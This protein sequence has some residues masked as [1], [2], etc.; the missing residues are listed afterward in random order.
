MTGT[1]GELGGDLRDRLALL[2]QASSLGGHLLVDYRAC[3]QSSLQ[4]L[5]EKAMDAALGSASSSSDGCHGRPVR[6]GVCGS[7]LVADDDALI[8]GQPL[9]PG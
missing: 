9:S 5:M 3:R 1:D 4:R 7:D 6:V 8:V 2:P